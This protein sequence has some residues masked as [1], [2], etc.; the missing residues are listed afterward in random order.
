MEDL[1]DPLRLLAD[2]RDVEVRL[3]RSFLRGP[4]ARHALGRQQ[5]STAFMGTPVAAGD[6]TL[7][8]DQPLVHGTVATASER[9]APSASVVSAA[10]DSRSI[11]AGHTIPKY[12][13]PKLVE[14]DAG[15]RQLSPGSLD[16]IRPHVPRPLNACVAECRAPDLRQGVE[17]P[18]DR[19]SPA[20]AAR[21]DR[22]LETNDEGLFRGQF[23]GR[24]VGSPAA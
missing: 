22:R 10:D 4:E 17:C 1:D 18:V 6:G 15:R 7:G 16:G 12:P 13:Q 9:Y 3:A 20:V 5:H 19:P 23:G 24:A 8:G 11:K 2:L 14:L 21:D